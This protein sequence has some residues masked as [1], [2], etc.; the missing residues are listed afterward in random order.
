MLSYAAKRIVRGVAV[1]IPLFLSVALAVTFFSGVLQGADAVGAAMLNKV[2]TASELDI[3]STA[4]GRNFTQLGIDEVMMRIQEVE[5][6]KSVDH[7]IRVEVELNSSEINASIIVIAFRSNSSLLGRVKGVEE[8][9]AG[10]AYVEAGS[11]EAS[12]FRIGENITLKISTW[13]PYSIVAGFEPRFCHL[14]VGGSVRID[15]DLFSVVTGRFPLL[16]R[17]VMLGAGPERRPPYR[18]LII[19]E[20]TLLAFLDSIY[21]EGRLPTRVMRADLI[22]ELDRRSLINPWSMEASEISVKQVFERVNSAGAQYM[23]VPV[24]YLGQLLEAVRANSSGL[25]I[26]TILVAMPVFFASWYLGMTVSDVALD[27]RRRE[28][29]LLLTRGMRRRQVFKILVFEAILTGFMAGLSGLIMGWVLTLTVLPNPGWGL[30]PPPAPATI[31]ISLLLSLSLSILSIYGPAQKA[32][33]MNLVESLR[34]PY[35]SDSEE[36]ISREG[37]FIALFLGGYKL[38]MLILGLNVD[39]FA[40]LTDNFVIFLLY[41]TW[42]GVDLILTYIGPILF[43]YGSIKLLIQ[44][45]RRPHELI[46]RV[47]GFVVGDLSS[48]STLRAHRDL[49]RVASSTLLLAVVMSYSLSMV[50]SVASSEDFMARTIRMTVGADAS[51]WL[52]SWRGA[53]ELD[54]RIAK[55]DGVLG[56]AVEAWLEADSAL[57]MIPIRAVDPN[58]W[59][60]VAYI[61]EGWI[62]GVEV[63]ER[64][65]S[66]ETTAMLERGAAERL[67]AELNDTM[68]IKL[69]T[70]VHTLTIVGLFGKRHP[71]GW[72]IQNPTVYVPLSFLD[73]IEESD[74]KR[75]RI[76][77]KL[78]EDIDPYTFSETVRALDPNIEGVD[79]AELKLMEASSNI[80]LTG[81]RRIEEIGVYI[82]S[83][84]SSVGV[85]LVVS[86]GLRSRWKE[87]VVMAI[88]GFSERQLASI[89]AVEYLSST[90]LAILLGSAVGYILLRGEIEMF[91]SISQASIERR[92]VFPV[93]AQLSLSAVL[94]LILISVVIPILFAARRI[95]LHPI[96]TQ[97]E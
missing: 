86:T 27:M 49:R 58:M 47:A 80:F 1:F 39:M 62:E 21:S 16:L 88:R 17:S 19:S 30:P 73:R 66:S 14:P 25:R 67:G 75:V 24:N 3:V 90:L 38:A 61:E 53:E 5:G 23:Y 85:A 57:G 37:P 64:M 22:I 72:T 35:L 74:I 29:A 87:I 96:W 41:S 76:L 50:G 34:G 63:L 82:A 54:D 10:R 51:I 26:S 95:S 81:S 89:L 70:R 44:L 93:G 28:V 71:M 36:K 56:T 60:D 79:I 77:V 2:L 55:L 42:W 13:L 7:I 31:S 59:R 68:L 91:N 6:V 46:G 20:E 78:R 65:N 69:G 12:D 52:F 9:E 15:E 32:M 8:L 92:I 4:E 83:I 45:S 11:A 33:K 97:E 40:P 43:L 84:I 94:G 18:L 48:I